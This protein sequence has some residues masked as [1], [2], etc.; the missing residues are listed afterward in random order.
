M[1]PGAF[2]CW[3]PASC[4]P[5]L[6]APARQRDRAFR[7]HRAYLQAT[8]GVGS[9]RSRLKPNGGEKPVPGGDVL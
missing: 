3:K 2:R 1:G 7:P 5:A 8:V 9:R 6:V 4:A